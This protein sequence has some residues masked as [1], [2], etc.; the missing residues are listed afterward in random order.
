MSRLSHWL[1]NKEPAVRLFADILML[2]LS[3]AR[4]CL[5]TDPP[6]SCT[7]CCIS[8]QHSGDLTRL[9]LTDMGLFHVICLLLWFKVVGS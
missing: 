4:L 7:E 8:E 1:H 2:T 3:C 9:L 5:S 6:R